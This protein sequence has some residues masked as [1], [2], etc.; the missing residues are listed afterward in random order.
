MGC[1]RYGLAVAVGLA[2]VVSGRAQ[3]PVA[4]PAP[5]PPPP[6]ALGAPVPLA[7]LAP[8]PPGADGSYPCQ[9]GAGPPAC[10][11][12]EDHNG[13][14]LKGDPNLDPACVPQPGWF[15]AVDLDF[16]GVH[17]KNRLVN[18]VTFAPTTPLGAFLGTQTVHLPGAPLD[19]TTAPA[20]ELGYRLDQGCGEFIL[21]YRSLVTEGRD[22]IAD[23]DVGPG[24]LRSRLN[25]NV[26]DLDYASREF[27]LWPHFDMKWHVGLR[28]ANVFYD[29]RALGL[30]LEER[31]SNTFNGLG[32]D[33]GL[34][35]RYHFCDLPG[36][37]VFAR[38][39]AAEM[40]G[41][42]RQS[43]EATVDL[44][45]ELVGAATTATKWQG[46][47]MIHL[48]LGLSYRPDWGKDQM[49]F[50]FGYEFEQWWYLG[51]VGTSNEELTANGVFFRAELNY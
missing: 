29:S 7:P 14:L 9:P 15:G 42:I 22:A 4:A 40:L 20:F 44:P 37:E 8:P 32:P 28:F 1:R 27:S 26:A 38:F 2:C 43:F 47:P 12:Y 3:A 10:A 21:G 11:P 6:A 35:L 24:D 39:D 23:F 46:V 48:Q 33:A 17:V 16:T 30:V 13:P 45:P 5:P 25:V 41:Q 31:T 34:D 50:S 49:R 36:F 51:S 19:W 18:S